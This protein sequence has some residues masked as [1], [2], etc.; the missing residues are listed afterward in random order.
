M[1]LKS[2]INLNKLK[3]SIKNFDKGEPFPHI[4]IDN[5]LK[6]KIAKKIEKNFLT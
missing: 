1:D 6:S 5:F 4:I 3:K 2:F